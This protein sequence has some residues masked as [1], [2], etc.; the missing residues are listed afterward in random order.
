MALER[1]K[2]NSIII[3]GELP[4]ELI[5]KAKENLKRLVPDA[6][7]HAFLAEALDIAS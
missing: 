1:E 2:I 4:D 3:L 6:A 7:E 5:A